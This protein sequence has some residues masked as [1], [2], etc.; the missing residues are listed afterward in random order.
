MFMCTCTNTEQ[1]SKLAGGQLKQ[2]YFEKSKNP[3]KGMETDTT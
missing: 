2:V 1:A 3:P